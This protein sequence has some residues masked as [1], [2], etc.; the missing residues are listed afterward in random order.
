LGAA[1]A[2]A[3]VGFGAMQVKAIKARKFSGGG[4]VSSGGAPSA[5]ST[6]APSAPAEPELAAP[7]LDFEET[8]TPFR[9]EVTVTASDPFTPSVIRDF[10]EKLREEDIAVNYDVNF[11]GG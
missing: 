8:A 9:Q 10:I 6:A 11:V 7:D 4:G 3:A 1:A 5:A 2:A